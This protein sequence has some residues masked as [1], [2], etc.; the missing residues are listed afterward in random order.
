[1]GNQQLASICGA[2]SEYHQQRKDLT[3]YLTKMT[4]KSLQAAKEVLKFFANK[5]PGFDTC[6]KQV[7]LVS[8]GEGRLRAEMTV[9]EDH[10]NR[11]GTL[12]GGMTATLVDA[13]S[14]IGLMTTGEG[15]P[16]VSVNINVSY[17]SAARVGEDIVIESETLKLGR[18]L[19]F[20]KVDISRKSDGK[21]IASGSHTKHLGG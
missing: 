5:G 2:H 18:T 19:A 12:H 7:N 8:A 16:G 17:I 6:M 3:G 15:R 20:L 14:T 21:L 9:T 11:G 10:Q 13:L 1:M 4:L